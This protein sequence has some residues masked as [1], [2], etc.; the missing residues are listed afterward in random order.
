VGLLPKSSLTPALA[1]SVVRLGVWAPFGIDVR[2]LE[3]FTHTQLSEPTL[4]RLTERAGAAYVAVQTAQAAALGGA[5][6]NLPPGP[7]LQQV[8]VDGAFVPLVGGG[9]TEVKTLAVGT[10][11]PPR[12]TRQGEWEVHTTDLSYFSRQAEAATFADLATVETH[13]RGV[14]S[15]GTVVGVVDGAVWE[16]GFLDLHCPDAVRILDWSH[17]VGYLADIARAVF[18]PETPE[19]MAWLAARRS[20]LFTQDPGVV[21]G[22]LRGLQEDLA[23][24]AGPGAP[25]AALAVVTDNLAYLEKRAD[26]LRYAEFRAAGYPI[27]SGIVES[28]NK[29]VVEARLK[30]AGM[31]WAPAHVTPLAALRAMACSDR[32]TEAWPQITAQLRHAAQ[33]GTAARRLARQAAAPAPVLDVGPAPVL[34]VPEPQPSRSGEASTPAPAPLRPPASAPGRG[35][36]PAPHRPAATHPWRARLLAPPP[37]L[38]PRPEM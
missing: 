24:Q 22:K 31:H 21:L 35:R 19:M 32:W 36:A 27:G 16:Q 4:T 33:A 5:T 30:G 29:L 20:E 12:Q 8:S 18:G 26:Q 23:A 25:P 7:P 6:A 14:L 15:A 17:A 1:E 37:A 34:A 13:R 3:H 2:M 38:T 28:G 10:V 9:W 11:S